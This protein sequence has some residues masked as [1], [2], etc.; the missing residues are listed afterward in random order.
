[1]QLQ[2]TQKK[3]EIM[4]CGNETCPL[5]GISLIP[6]SSGKYAIVD[7]ADYAW[8]M[9][10]TWYAR[11]NRRTWYAG[12]TVFGPRRRVYMHRVILGTP[13]GEIVDHRYG[14][15][16]DNRRVIIRPCTAQQNNHN[17]RI[18][19]N[20]TSGFK[21]VSWRPVEK[22]WVANIMI[23]GRCLYLGYFCCIVKAARAYDK[24]AKENFGEF[25]CL[26]FPDTLVE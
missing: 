23:G 15:G 1:M 2:I 8:L 3:A 18:A 13:K 24:A 6:L 11:L 19:K 21:G 26:N 22:K 5:L 7:I 12:R 9:Q 20:N 10:W 25:A 16:L 14:Y 17:R 4:K